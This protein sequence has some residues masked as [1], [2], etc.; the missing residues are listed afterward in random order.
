MEKAEQKIISLLDK[1]EKLSE[2]YAPEVVEK[3]LNA[4]QVTGAGNLLAG[5]LCLVICGTIFLITKRFYIY[6]C[7]QYEKDRFS[8]WNLASSISV[9][10]GAALFLIFLIPAFL[11]LGD[12]WN[13]VA[14]FRPDLALAHKILGV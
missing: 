11:E 12:L 10:F 14:I 5:F 4:I 3:T 13:W 6:A 7:S 2:Q 8:S 1:F 9:A